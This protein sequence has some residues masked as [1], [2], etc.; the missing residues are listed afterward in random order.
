MKMTKRGKM[1]LSI[2]CMGALLMAW[3]MIFA[4]LDLGV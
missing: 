3:A 4:T 1:V 2:L